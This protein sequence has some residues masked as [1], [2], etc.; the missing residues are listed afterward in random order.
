[1][2]MNCMLL[3]SPAAWS[4]TPDRTQGYS[5]AVLL[6]PGERLRLPFTILL[7]T[8]SLIS[9]GRD[10]GGRS[11]PNI[12]SQLQFRAAS[13]S[14]AASVGTVAWTGGS[15]RACA[16]PTTGPTA[17]NVRLPS[18]RGRGPSPPGAF[19]RCRSAP[20]KMRIKVALI[21][22][23]RLVGKRR[24]SQ[25]DKE[26]L[27][28]L[29]ESVAT[30]TSTWRFHEPATYPSSSSRTFVRRRASRMVSLTRSSE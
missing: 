14:E 27:F 4:S 1:M 23:R 25:K 20:G 26:R 9:G 15:R 19:W 30:Q 6:H 29:V 12:C 16:M 18:G 17:G 2:M 21:A 24:V 8:P 5:Q 10:D 7:F 3:V 13:P 22:L 11:P 28:W